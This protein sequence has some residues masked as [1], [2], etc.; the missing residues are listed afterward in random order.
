MG[1][2]LALARVPAGPQR[3]SESPPASD[4][5]FAGHFPQLPRRAVAARAGRSG[6]GHGGR[7]SPALLGSLFTPLFPTHLQLSGSRGCQDGPVKV[8]GF[9]PASYRFSSWDWLVCASCTGGHP[10]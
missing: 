7:G 8:L 9:G 1:G 10:P 3:G 4:A 6:A 2:G 5:H